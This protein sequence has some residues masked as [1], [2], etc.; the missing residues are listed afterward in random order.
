M[1]SLLSTPVE[2]RNLLTFIL[3]AV[4]SYINLHWSSE[5]QLET[6]IL[7]VK[8][9]VILIIPSV[10]YSSTFYLLFLS[11]KTLQHTSLAIMPMFFP[12]KLLVKSGVYPLVI[13]TWHMK[14]QDD[15]VLRWSIKYNFL[16][17][18]FSRL[19]EL[20]Q[21]LWTFKDTLPYIFIKK[22]NTWITAIFPG[23]WMLW[24]FR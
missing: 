23:L 10:G 11:D 14:V 9:I 2:E 16:A 1:A 18:P 5:H 8:S 22:E 19:G 24:T 21:F 7:Y 17:W 3:F 13:E 20:E 12:A 4:I 15:Y 6:L